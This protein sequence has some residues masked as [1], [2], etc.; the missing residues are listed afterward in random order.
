MRLPDN[1]NY[2]VS[3]DRLSPTVLFL[4]GFM[5]SSADWRGAMSALGDRTFCIAADLPG[6]GASLGL[7][8]DTYTIEGAT[9]TAISILDELGV[10]HPVLAGYSMGGRLALY[11]ALR[12]PERCAGLFLESASPGLE[13]ASEREA[14]RAADESKATRLESGDLETFLRDWY[15]Q[16]LFSSLARDENLLRRTIDA[17]RRNDPGELALSLRG[18]G[19]GSQPSLW[20]EL[21]HLAVPTLTVAGELDGKYVG[22]SSRMASINSRIESAVVPGAG[23]TV[24]AEA[25]TAYISLL[26]SFV[27]GLSLG[28][29][30]AEPVP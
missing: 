15:R 27:D 19:T 13:G 25:P 29:G 9:G 24:H 20:G 12:Y 4:H 14:R 10:V 6:H 22:I 2:E 16:P 23:H 30:E 1:L 28:L 26:G 17:R 8:L 7:P 3:G 18:M 11:L 5:G 21:E